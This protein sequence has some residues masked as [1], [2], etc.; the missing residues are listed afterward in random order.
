M[1]LLIPAILC[2][3]IVAVGFAADENEKV[4]VDLR[5]VLIEGPVESLVASTRPPAAPSDEPTKSAPARSDAGTPGDVGKRWIEST[6]VRAISERTGHAG[7][8]D[9]QRIRFGEAAT[10][11]DT[12]NP[13]VK[14]GKVTWH[15]D[16]A[17]ACRRAKE[18]GKPVLLFQMMGRLDQRFT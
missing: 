9:Q 15:A 6:T 4:P 17:T 1:K 13:T 11:A 7:G 10:T 14:P 12:N 8:V 2:G 3:A 16:L 18:S 5:K